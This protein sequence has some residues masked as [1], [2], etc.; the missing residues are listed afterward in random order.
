[1]IRTRRV[2]ECPRSDVEQRDREGFVSIGIVIAVIVLL[3]AWADAVVGPSGIA[4]KLVKG[5]AF[6]GGILLGNAAQKKMARD[7]AEKVRVWLDFWDDVDAEMQTLK[8]R[9]CTEPDEH[10]R[11]MAQ[12]DYETLKSF[13]DKYYR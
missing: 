4:A 8:H 11:Y 3:W 9:S 5:G 6:V 13:R 12:N 10:D 7:H 2:P 1:M